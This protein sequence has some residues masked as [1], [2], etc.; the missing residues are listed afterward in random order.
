[1]Y[2]K[3]TILM[4]SPFYSP[5]IGGV[6]THLD[7]LIKVLNK[8]KIRSIVSTYQ[9]LTTRIKG[10]YIEKIH[11]VRI[12]RFPWFGYNWF[13]I[14]EKYPLLTFLY[15]FPGLFIQTSF[16]LFEYRNTISC[17]HAHGY[18]AGLVVRLLNPFYGKKLIFSTH[19]LY[20]LPKR[21]ILAKVILWILNGFNRILTLSDIS[22]NELV[23]SG[24]PRD[25]IQRY[26][27]WVDQ[28]IFR[29]T[30]KQ[31]SKK[32]LGWTDKTVFLF[33][34]RLIEIKGVDIFLKVAGKIKNKNILF[35]IVGTGP[36]E[37]KVYTAAR[38]TRN[39]RYYGRI[40]NTQLPLLYNAA[41][42]LLVPSKYPE[43]MARV[44]MESL[45]C[46]TPVIA[47]RLGCLPGLIK[48]QA[49]GMLV[50]P[51]VSGFMT[52]ID[53]IR[54]HGVK[55]SETACS[56]FAQKHFSEKN[57]HEILDTYVNGTH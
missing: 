30:N 6:E 46:G 10:K 3:N 45:S 39:V 8:R 32:Q 13:P 31:E 41:D 28:E 17:I 36:E 47:S 57:A 50:S 23:A 37:K 2:D 26:T 54:P 40:E 48:D 25:R 16:L 12:Y 43:G 11:G 21:P 29:K 19:A 44:V 24:F 27:Y 7:D 53:G 5:N 4:V 22:T 42:W 20:S 38:T 49:T 52:A 51:S 9:P 56:Q 34:G 14:L 35:V 33:I 1:M 15:L 18:I 55:F